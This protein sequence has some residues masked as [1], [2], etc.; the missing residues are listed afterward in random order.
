LGRKENFTGRSD[1]WKAV[2]PAAKDPIFGA[3]FESFWIS[4][5]LLDR[6]YQQL[7]GWPRGLNTAHNGYIETYLNL[8]WVG[9]CLIAV[10]LISGY[11]RAVAC[12]RRDPATGGL[13]LA[14][15]ATAMIY[16]ITEAG[17]RMLTLSW[18]FLLLV[19]VNA[20]GL[21][22]GHLRAQSSTKPI[23]RRMRHYGRSIAPSGPGPLAKGEQDSLEV[24][25]WSQAGEIASTVTSRQIR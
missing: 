17:F 11:M 8:G 24:M 3:G 7:P 12:F 18:V 10:I 13:A 22:R 9:I 23:R 6:L 20:S 19:F 21:S 2:I 1:I 4:P 25:G 15:V 5:D 14:F 16:N